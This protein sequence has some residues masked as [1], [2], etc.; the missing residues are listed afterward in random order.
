MDKLEQEI[1]ESLNEFT[2]YSSGQTD[3]TGMDDTSIFASGVS[4]AA[5]TNKNIYT[6]S[7]NTITMTPSI[8]TIQNQQYTQQYTTGYSH[9]VNKKTYTILGKEIELE[10]IWDLNVINSIALIN[11]HGYKVYK[12]LKKN[13]ICFPIDLDKAIQNIVKILERDDKIND[14]CN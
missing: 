12:E 7:I 5:S 4:N 8:I 2:I 3:F 11:I 10:E 1:K 13:H 9:I 14:L 6:N